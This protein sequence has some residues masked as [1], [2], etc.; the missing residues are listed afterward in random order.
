[1]EYS[2]Y[3]YIICC[4]KLIFN[5]MQENIIHPHVTYSLIGRNRY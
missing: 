1:M 3:I 2:K 5:S 4:L